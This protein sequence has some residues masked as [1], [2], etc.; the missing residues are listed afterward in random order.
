[1]VFRMNK[2]LWKNLTHVKLLSLA[3]WAILFF[4]YWINNEEQVN[5]SK[6][7]TMMQISIMWIMM[8]FMPLV[9]CHCA[10]NIHVILEE[11]KWIQ[12]K[13]HQLT[14]INSVVSPIN[15]AVE[16][17][18]TSKRTETRVNLGGKGNHSKR[19]FLRP[20]YLSAQFFIKVTN[21]LLNFSRISERVLISIFL[22]ILRICIQSK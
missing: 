5:I 10:I 15:S 11:T 8:T 21:F 19:F 17:S 16:K 4:I 6:V 14:W 3:L 22:A 12:A 7:S 9:C 20:S 13:Y 1:M 18:S 2:W